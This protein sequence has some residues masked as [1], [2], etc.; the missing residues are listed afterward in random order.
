MAEIIVDKAM[1]EPAGGWQREVEKRD[2]RI[3]E[4]EVALLETQRLYREQL[5][6]SQSM[7]KDVKDL[8]ETV[9]RLQRAMHKAIAD[10]SE[11]L[12]E[13]IEWTKPEQTTSSQ[14]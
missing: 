10:L 4:L 9:Y 6:F 2:K 3:A 5:E 11:A 12:R 13:D 1:W 7:V 14:D 8:E